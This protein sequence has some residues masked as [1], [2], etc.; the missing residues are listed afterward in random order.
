MTTA[1]DERLAVTS[2]PALFAVDW[3]T[4]SL[5]AYLCTA[6]G[7][8]I[9]TVRSSDGIMAVADQRFSDILEQTLAPWRTRH[10]D[11]PV[12]LSGMIGSRQGWREVPYV[13]LAAR[14]ADVAK[15]AIRVPCEMAAPVMI[16]PGIAGA[17]RMGLPDV[18][19]GE[20]TQ[21][22]GAMQRMGIDAGTFVLPGT[23]AKWVTVSDGAIVGF[24]TYM[25]GDA[26]AALRGHT[27][28][29]RMMPEGS[30]SREGFARGV[31]TAAGLPGGP[32][33]LLHAVFSARTLGLMGEVPEDALADYLSGL[34]IGAEIREGAGETANVI[35]VGDAKLAGR[36]VEACGILGIPATPAP[37]DCV[38]AG[39]VAIARAAGIVGAPV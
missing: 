15:A 9:D 6:Q 18:M 24:E 37:A 20:E 27:I 5:R 25:T 16:A 39:L 11:V 33:A 23:H 13:G 30:E 36:Y 4:S 28:L 1:G 3:G 7:R 19:R 8:V 35:V 12:V 10:G 34:L 22:F 31:R 26:Y 17:D 38:V 14:L 32:G 2:S 29:G 21:I